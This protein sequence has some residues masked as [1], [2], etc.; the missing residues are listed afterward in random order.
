MSALVVDCSVAVSWC[1]RDQADNYADRV[2]EEVDEKGAVVPA[3]WPLEL[4]NVLLVAERRK[5]VGQAEVTRLLVFIGGLP[6]TIDEET[7]HRAF[8]AILSLGR[9]QRVSSYDAPYLELAARLGL[10]LASRDEG[11]KKAARSLG[12]GLF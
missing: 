4:A 6:I 3:I 11:M 9:E 2:L 1:F 8:D 7:P 12:I 5:K 10:P